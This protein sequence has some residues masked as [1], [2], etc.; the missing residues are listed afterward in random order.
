MSELVSGRRY[1]VR[2][3]DCC[4]RGE[5]TGRFIEIPEEYVYSFDFGILEAYNLLSFQELSEE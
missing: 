5:L 3:K 1:K 2:F 4:V